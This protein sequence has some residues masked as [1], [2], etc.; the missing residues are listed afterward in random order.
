MKRLISFI[1]LILMLSQVTPAGAN[2]MVMQNSTDWNLGPTGMLVI[3][4]DLDKNKKADFFSLREVKS[5]FFSKK[6]LDQISGFW[7][8]HLVFFVNYGSTSYYYII[9]RY[10]MLYAIDTDQDGQWDFIYKDYLQDG[11]NANEQFYD[12]PS[13]MALPLSGNFLQQKSRLKQFS[14]QEFQPNTCT[15]PPGGTLSQGNR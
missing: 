10:P 7:P 8:D 12:N 14:W 3:D 2:S 4:Y 9:A 5:S 15:L 11:L 1:T 13:G 6:P